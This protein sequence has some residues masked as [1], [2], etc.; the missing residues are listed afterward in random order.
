[1]NITVGSSKYDFV[2]GIDA[3]FGPLELVSR[4][5]WQ[6]YKQDSVE[7][8]FSSSPD[9]DIQWTAGAYWED[10]Y[11]D[12]DRLIDIN[13]EVGGLAPILFSM[14]AIPWRSLF[15]TPPGVLIANAQVN[16]FSI[17]IGIGRSAWNRTLC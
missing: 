6:E 5:D 4:D 7:I 10:Q 3:D 8:R 12:I 13:G 2:D 15:T 14:G 9:S 1:M 16:P 11:Q 17:P